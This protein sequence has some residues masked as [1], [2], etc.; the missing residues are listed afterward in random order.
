[1]TPA[2]APGPVFYAI[3]TP[4]PAPAKIAKLRLRLL[5]RLL[6]TS[7]LGALILGNVFGRVPTALAYNESPNITF[8]APSTTLLHLFYKRSTVQF[9]SEGILR[10][11]GI[12]LSTFY[13]RKLCCLYKVTSLQS[14]A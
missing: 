4:A 2:P 12:F 10:F 6:I 1:M 7:S 5:L 13:V 9:G 8:E 11:H 14:N 3:T